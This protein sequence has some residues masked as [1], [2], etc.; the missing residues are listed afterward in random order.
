MIEEPAD[1]VPLLDQRIYGLSNGHQGC[2]Q[3]A[4]LDAKYGQSDTA[5]RSLIFDITGKCGAD[6]IEH[7]PD[8]PSRYEF[9]SLIDNAKYRLF[10]N[11]RKFVGHRIPPSVSDPVSFDGKAAGSKVA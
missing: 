8:L 4:G 1:H 6:P 11:K 2:D 10:F 9:V 5:V 3:T 7:D